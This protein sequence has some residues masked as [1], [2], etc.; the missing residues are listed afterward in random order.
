INICTCED[1][2]KHLKNWLSG[3]IIPRSLACETLIDHRQDGSPGLIQIAGTEA[4][5]MN[6]LKKSNESICLSELVEQ[7][8]EQSHQPYCLNKDI[9]KDRET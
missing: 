7:E 9:N 6:A 1:T 4:E 2:L 3:S 8:L 5:A